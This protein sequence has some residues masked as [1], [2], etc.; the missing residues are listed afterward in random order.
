MYIKRY[1]PILFSIL[2]VALVLGGMQMSAVPVMAAPV[3]SDTGGLK[4][5]DL[6][7]PDGS[8]QTSG[9]SGSLDLTG[10]DVKL[11]PQRGP[12]FSSTRGALTYTW[13][14]VG[15]G[16]EI[17]DVVYAIAVSGTNVYVG[18]DFSSLT[19]CRDCK[20]IAKWDGSNWSALGGGVDFWVRAISISGTDVYVGGLFT[21]ATQGDSSTCADCNKIAKWDGSAWSPLGKGTENTVTAIAISGSNVYAGGNF[22]YTTQ[23]DETTCDNCNKIAKWDGSDWSALGTGINDGNDGG[24]WA[25]ATNGTDVYAGGNFISVAGCETPANCYG[26]AK[27]NASSGWSALG[28]GIYAENEGFVR[29]LATNGTSV[30]AGGTFDS[31]GSCATPSNCYGIAKW[32]GSKWSALEQGIQN[33]EVWAITTNGTDVFVGG[34]FT[35]LGSSSYP[36]YG[37]FSPTSCKGIA[38]WNDGTGWQEINEGTNAQV[39]GLVASGSD[40]WAV[41]AFTSAGE[42][43]PANYI[44]AYAADPA[45]SATNPSDGQTLPIASSTLEVQFN[46]VVLH[47]SSAYSATSL[48]NYMLVSAGKDAIFQTLDSSAAICNASHTPAGDDVNISIASIEYDD[49]TDTATLT[50]AQASLPLPA[51]SYRLYVCGAASIRDLSGQPIYGGA[52]FTLSFSASAAP[53]PSPTPAPSNPGNSSSFSKKKTSNLPQT[54]FAPNVKTSLP[55]QP[56]ALAYTKMSS[57]WLEIPSQNI[58]AE[59]VGVPQV[60]NNWD[61]AWLGRNAGWLNGSAY[62]T[63]TGNSVITAH[64]T[65][66]N[67]KPGLF[68]NLKNLGYGNKLI[69]HQFGSKYTYEVRDTR[70]VFPDTTG[71]AFEHLEGKSYLTLI[72]CQGYNFLTDSYMFRRVVRAVLMKVEAE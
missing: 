13:K 41:G 61:V 43:S 45:V 11:D 19:V 70:M 5:A 6:L 44:A 60:D 37:C 33:G 39:N 35:S 62:P 68:A 7:N 3:S 72:T 17:K 57:L 67:G 15:L 29:A 36:V 49:I 16:M 64:V 12:V 42:T 46:K 52:N 58:K 53:G 56:A 18:G 38:K 50:I 14:A 2:I 21:T 40:I 26:I 69:V 54:G 10:W 23:A 65:D 4:V 71:Y 20:Y 47:D 34:T 24:V 32:D 63:W 48:A 59:I 30:Y 66:A 1:N 9:V 28:T 55:A 27:W 31:V 8:L 51:G 22:T 25:L